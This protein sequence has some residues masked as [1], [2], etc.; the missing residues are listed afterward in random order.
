MRTSFV[1]AIV[2]AGTHFLSCTSETCVY[3][4]RGSTT[5]H[6]ECFEESI[7]HRANTNTR[8]RERRT[9]L[10]K[11][12]YGIFFFFFFPTNRVLSACESL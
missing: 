7:G 10:M 11:Y 9:T 8:N 2:T 6:P 1:L 3:Q 5:A 4:G 12:R